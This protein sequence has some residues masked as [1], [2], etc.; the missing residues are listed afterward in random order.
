MHFPPFPLQRS[1]PHP[2]LSSL[3]FLFWELSTC[4]IILRDR[5]EPRW[6]V[7]SNWQGTDQDDDF[8]LEPLLNILNWCIIQRSLSSAHA[9]KQ[10]Y[11]QAEKKEPLHSHIIKH[12]SSVVNEVYDHVGWSEGFIYC[13]GLSLWAP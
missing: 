2:F 9:R 12:T 6:R 10:K 5:A 4:S 3:H 11:H 7:Y 1:F 13:P 8:Y